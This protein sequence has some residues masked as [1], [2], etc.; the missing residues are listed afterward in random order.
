MPNLYLYYLRL[1]DKYD[2]PDHWTDESRAIIS[3]HAEFL[4]ALGKTGILLFAGR[5]LFEPGD[6]NLFGIAVIRADSLDHAQ[7][8]MADDPAVLNGIQQAQIFPW[9]LSIEYFDNVR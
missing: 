8:I 1:T 2:K 7:S 5:T 3:R 9:R 4:D 6:A